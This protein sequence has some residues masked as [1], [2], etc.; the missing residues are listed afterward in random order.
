MST[1]TW[2]K[3]IGTVVVLAFLGGCKDSEFSHRREVQQRVQYYGPQSQ[4][5]TASIRWQMID[6]EL[7][8]SLCARPSLREL[9]IITAT[10]NGSAIFPHVGKLQNLETLNIIEVPLNDD[11]LRSLSEAKRLTSLELS[12]TGISGYGLQY[13]AK[14]PIKR[15]VIRDKQLSLEGLQ[16]IA[17]M[18]ELEELELCISGLRLADMP[19]LASNQKL[20]SVIITDAHFSYREF[21]GL[22]FLM[23]A[24]NLRELHLSGVNLNDRS[25]KSIGSLVNL[26]SLTIGECMISEE[27]IEHL[28]KLEHLRFVDAPTFHSL[29]HSMRLAESIDDEPLPQPVRS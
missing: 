19:T 29:Q 12:R 10:R 25:L 13:L 26:R 7:M 22:K 6:G 11:E 1:A 5:H 27:G 14:L 24:T 4:P 20:K 16:A 17:R 9:N 21:G 18:T 15:L 3:C 8:Q 28:A 23:G 2:K